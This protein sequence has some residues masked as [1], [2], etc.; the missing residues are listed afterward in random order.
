MAAAEATVMSAS[1]TVFVVMLG[2]ESRRRTEGSHRNN[3]LH[4]REQRLNSFEKCAFYNCS[5][6]V[7][8]SGMPVAF[9]TR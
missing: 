8:Y 7:V 5:L 9:S 6:S 4:R 1:K 3:Q 2:G